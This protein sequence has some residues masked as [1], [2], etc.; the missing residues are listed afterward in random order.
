MLRFWGKALLFLVTGETHLS[1]AQSTL[2]APALLFLPAVALANL[3]LD[4]PLILRLAYTTSIAGF[5]GTRVRRVNRFTQFRVGTVV[6][7]APLLLIFSWSAETRWHFYMLLVLHGGIYLA[8]LLFT[9]RG[10]D[11]YLHDEFPDEESP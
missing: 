3:G 4:P 9:S 11:L 2:L 5:I 8:S 10:N 1:I 6:S 7:A